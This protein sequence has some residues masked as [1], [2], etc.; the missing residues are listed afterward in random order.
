MEYPKQ[1]MKISEL[2]KMGFS[3][4]FLLE[5]YR[6][7]RQT[8]ATKMNPFKSNSPIIFDTTE[9]DKWISK[10]IKIQTDEFARQRRR[11]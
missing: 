1:I 4:P 6:D 7:P 8:F 11:Q 9:L 5:A 2:K 3:E 10:K